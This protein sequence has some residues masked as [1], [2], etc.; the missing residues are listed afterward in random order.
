MVS[1]IGASTLPG[2]SGKSAGR[3]AAG[4]E[5]QLERLQKELSS[6]VNCDSANTLQGKETI[7]AV[8][9]KISSVKARIEAIEIAKQTAPN[10]ATAINPAA[11]N[12]AL[13]SAPEGQNS[14]APLARAGENSRSAGSIIDVRA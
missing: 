3:S 13:V 5:A 9:N 14:A 11:N 1:A 7:Q 10:S 6:C 8:S 12:N 4:L 2:A